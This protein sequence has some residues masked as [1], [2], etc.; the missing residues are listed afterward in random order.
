M[1]IRKK[2][3]ILY[4]PAQNYHVK[5]IQEWAKGTV[6]I[7][8]IL[9]KSSIFLTQGKIRSIMWGERSKMATQ[10]RDTYT[11]SV[12]EW[13]HST[14]ARAS[15]WRNVNCSQH[16][17]PIWEL[18]VPKDSPDQCL[19]DANITQHVPL[20]GKTLHRRR[21]YSGSEPIKGSAGVD[22]LSVSCI[23]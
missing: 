4:W 23:T 20:L 7:K 10:P 22:R 15:I 12:A 3:L 21:L 8:K 9:Q 14:A 5:K 17:G 6:C 13:R 2:W 19:A 16:N 18:M 11:K 1:Q